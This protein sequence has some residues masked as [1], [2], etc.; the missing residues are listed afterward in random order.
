MLNVKPNFFLLG[1]WCYFCTGITW[2]KRFFLLTNVLRNYC[3]SVCFKA[4][5]SI[6]DSNWR[7]YSLVT[8]IRHNCIP[9][10]ITRGVIPDN[11]TAIID[12]THWKGSS[13]VD[14]SSCVF[15][16][17]A[18]NF[19]TRSLIKWETRIEWIIENTCLYVWNQRRPMLSEFR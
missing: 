5:F 10:P 18:R 8:Y 9:R 19:L 12:K 4:Y 6:N 14:V 2:M 11:I 3:E 7:V 1:K 17:T 16:L 13:D 15:K